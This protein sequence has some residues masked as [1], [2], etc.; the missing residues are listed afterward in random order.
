MS[1]AASSMHALYY[2]VV[3]VVAVDPSAGICLNGSIAF[4][5]DYIV[6]QRP[7]VSI[8][9]HTDT[10]HGR[11]LDAAISIHRRALGGNKEFATANR[12]IGQIMSGMGAHF[13]SLD[14]GSQVIF[15]EGICFWIYF[16]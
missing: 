4:H 1:S 15:D 14:R 13:L 9:T 11:T 8:H 12:R 7:I 16:G 5:P 6:M 2:H 3:C 10:N